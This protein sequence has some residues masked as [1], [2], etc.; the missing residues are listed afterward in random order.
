MKSFVAAAIG[1]AFAVAP[2]SAA[3]NL[4]I[5]TNAYIT[6]NGLDWAWGAPLPN[7]YFSDALS[8]QGTQGWRLPT[9][10][11]LAFAPVGTDFMFS[12]A[13]VPLGG[14]DAASGSSFQATNGALT[15]AAACA[16]G[17]FNTGYSHCDWQDGGQPWAGMNGASSYADQLYVRVSTQAVPE[18]AT[19]AMMIVG[20]GA[21]GVSMRRRSVNVSFA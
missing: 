15:G 6:V 16:A 13:N 20:M 14:S 1:A 21:V 12:G 5:P 11:E 19:W 2:A 4:P 18:L 10:A 17:Y 3:I 8:Y 7:S 9:L